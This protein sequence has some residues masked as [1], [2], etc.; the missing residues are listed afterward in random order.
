M[1]KKRK[2]LDAPVFDHWYH[3]RDFE[4]DE[5]R[6][7]IGCRLHTHVTSLEGS[8]APR[9][10]GMLKYASQYQNADVTM[11]TGLYTGD[12]EY[13]EMPR[14]ILNTSQAII[15]QLVAKQIS[16]PSKPTFDV[17]DGDFDAS[18]K[19]EQLDKFVWGEFYRLKTYRIHGFAFRDAVAWSGDGWVFYSPRNGKV[20]AE[21]ANPLEVFI[22]PMA[23]V[24]MPPREESTACGTWRAL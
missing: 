1:A 14:H 8:Q 24:S 11:R 10:D 5:E 20:H 18:L 15:D 7:E 2:Q 9:I 19:A 4:D 13:P 22:D 3:I 21:R 12:I 23:C 6:D 16:N 17:D